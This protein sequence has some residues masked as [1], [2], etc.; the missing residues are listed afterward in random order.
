[1]TNPRIHS[2]LVAAGML[3]GCVA[4]QAE[5][6]SV[7]AVEARPLP[8]VHFDTAARGAMLSDLHTG[9]AE[10]E[11]I[12]A[13]RSGAACGVA[14]GREWSEL[15]RSRVEAELPQVF[16]EEMAQAAPAAHAPAGAPLQ[17]QA[18]LNDIE[19]ELC[20]AGAGAWRGGFYVQLSWQVVS[21]ESGK[22]VY[23]ASTEGSYSLAE[24]RRV[25]AA[26]GLH[27]AMAV[28]VRK[29]L[30][31]RRFSAMLQPAETRRVASLSG[32]Y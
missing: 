18:F 1:M 13:V 15:I 26:A 7:R 24:P 30:V 2:T 10:G 11:P 8:V 3:L 28:A 32:A 22:V 25:A 27:E 9:F 29:L 20:D 5:S 4:A 31:D 14:V 17:V 19:V 16:A 23:Q 12:G 6:P 21:P